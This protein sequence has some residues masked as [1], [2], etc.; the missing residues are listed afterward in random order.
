MGCLLGGIRTIVLSKY[1][2][3]TLKAVHKSCPSIANIKS[4]SWHHGGQILVDT[5]LFL[6]ALLFN[7][8]RQGLVLHQIITS[9]VITAIGE[10]PTDLMDF[11]KSENIHTITCTDWLS[12]LSSYM[13]KYFSNVIAPLK[14]PN[15]FW[16]LTKYP[17]NE[18]FMSD[19]IL[20]G[21]CSRTLCVLMKHT[22]VFFLP[23]LDSNETI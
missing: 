21:D 14:L 1:L 8:S 17:M 5:D 3:H 9:L 18:H 16:G 22:I 7:L 11:F 19:L 13:V 6:I 10:I 15:S 12:F 23:P 2:H 4:F 20:Q